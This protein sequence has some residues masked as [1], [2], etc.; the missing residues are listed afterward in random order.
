[1]ANSNIQSTPNSTEEATTMSN[2]ENLFQ[3]FI[4]SGGEPKVTQF[5]RFIDS[6]INQHI[7]KLCSRSGKA[8]DGNDW[9]SE[10]KARFAG[11]GKKWVFV[12]LDEIA[13]SYDRLESMGIETDDYKAWTTE[14]GK[15]WIRF[16][17]DRINEGKQSAAFEVRT[18]GSTF[19]CPK[20]LHY[21]P[22]DELD[23]KITF[24]HTTP[25][26]MRLEVIAPKKTEE[27]QEAKLTEDEIQ[28]DEQLEAMT[29][30]ATDVYGD[31][32]DFEE[33]LDMDDDIFSEI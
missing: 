20:S 5:K 33:E 2:I 8:A 4:Q 10:L 3:E 30:L 11:R 29:E 27:P 18:I 16:A 13:T 32:L 9:R 6:Q 19:D 21:I 24:M 1:M 28:E 26:A 14:A 25:H 31:D 7:K 15:A 12:S 17:G 23:D 22:V